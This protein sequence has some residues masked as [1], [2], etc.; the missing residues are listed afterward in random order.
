MNN[1]VIAVALSGGIDSLVSGYLLKQK[2]KNVFGIHFRTGYEKEPIDSSLLETQLGFSVSC[3]DLSRPFEE[4]VISYFIRTYLKGKTP[5]PCI[6]CNKEIKFGEL[7]IQAQ[8]MGADYLATGHYATVINPFSFP[9]RKISR[10]YLEKALDSRKDQTYFLSM[11]TSTQLEKIIFPL[12]DMRKEEVKAFARTKNIRPFHPSESQDICFIQDNDFSKF[13]LEKQNIKSAQGNIVDMDGKIVGRHGGLHRFTIGQRKGINSP[14]GEAYYV[15]RIDIENN[16]LE[17]CF[18][19]DL[20]TKRFQVKDINWNDED[21][22]IIPDIIT[23]IRYSH[24]GAL[25]TLM[26][27]GSSGEVV[28]HEAQNAVTPGQAAV[29]YKGARVLGAGIIQ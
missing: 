28:F 26:M 18:K 11:L 15:K 7:M 27:K 21:Q 6:V 1:P 2:Y 23:K 4:K 16:T 14:A 25:S 13:I 22:E 10:A 12:A 17:V 24:Q 9:E 20:S 29:F 8:Q 19:K 5:N 3:I